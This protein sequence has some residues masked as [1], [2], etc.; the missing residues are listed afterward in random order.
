MET[1]AA[2]STWPVTWQGCENRSLW[3]IS[4]GKAGHEAQ[5][6]GVAAA[7]GVESVIKRVAPKGICKLAA[8]W[9]PV[10]PS[11]R[12]GQPGSQFASPWP[13]VA[14]AT[15]RTTIPYLRALKRHAG[16]QTLT[17]ILMDPRTRLSSADLIWVPQHD[18]LRGPNVI[19]TLTAPHVYSHA[20]L[21]ALR[22]TL[23]PEIANLPR[24][25]FSVLIGGPNAAYR[26]EP[27]DVERLKASITSL[28]ASGA[29]VMV[30]ISRRTPTEL[31]EALSAAA[32]HKNCLFWNGQGKNLYPE[33]L[34]H[35]DAFIVTAD[36][37]S[38][39]CEA[40]STGRP[41]YVFT[42]SGVG[43]KFARFHAALRKHGATRG[44]PERI[45]DIMTD[46]DTWTYEPL[47][48]AQIIADEIVRR[49]EARAQMIPGLME[50]A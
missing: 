39:T 28:V 43:G 31:T 25:R 21:D 34:A 4:D 8:P 19:A 18:E 26:Y 14:L 22:A 49:W 29:G 48:S 35:A 13:T 33:F 10:A 41:I 11:E 16:L 46:M 36:S 23:P 7:L 5:C 32:A 17:V 40:A 50:R 42:P 15:G 12:F 24:P 3:I 30:T 38:M 37:V 20:R 47:N 27:D 44:L 2:P 9:G 45:T 6:L 1:N